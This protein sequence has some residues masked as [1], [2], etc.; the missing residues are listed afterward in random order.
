MRFL[1]SG[2]FA[3]LCC[4]T[5]N[6]LIH[7]DQ[8]GL[9]KP[10][11]VAESGYRLYLAS[12]RYRFLSVKA[13][14]DSGMPLQEVKRVL[15]TDDA[16]ELAASLD[17]TRDEIEARIAGLRES[18]ARID[19]VARQAR[20]ACEMGNGSISLASRPVRRLAVLGVSA[21]GPDAFSDA[22][23]VRRDLEV[24]R[25]LSEAGPAAEL[26]PYGCMCT[27]AP[28]PDGRIAYDDLFYVL[29]DGTAYRGATVVI[30]AGEY[31]V[32]GYDGPFSEVGHAHAALV[33]YAREWGLRDDLPRYEIS[34]L[35]ML[36]QEGRYR[37]TV[38]MR[39]SAT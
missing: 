32:A 21:S 23:V 36:D 8:M 11:R 4:T 30:E 24:A 18:L 20:A 39:V 35:K 14:A 1:K 37:C 17:A 19:E 5:K 7:Y 26:S 29:P 6:T 10:A 31:V 12:Q 16:H 13:L 33:D 2:E 3:K 9:L 27:T 34:T 38:E 28:A 15:D 22:A 25:L